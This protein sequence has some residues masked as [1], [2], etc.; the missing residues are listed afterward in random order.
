[1]PD[2]RVAVRTTADAL[3]QIGGGHPWLY[4]DSIT[5]VSDPSAPS[6]SLAVVFDAKRRFAAIGL[7]DPESPIRVR[8]LHAGEARPIDDSFWFELVAGA[9]E[10]RAGLPAE[11]TTAYRLLN[12]ENDGTGGL[13]ADLYRDTIVVKV[14]TSAWI[15]HLRTVLDALDIV[16]GP[17]RIV[18]R[19]GRAMARSASTSAAGLSDGLTIRGEPPT[20]PVQYTENGLEF[21]A[22][23][24]R[25]QK[26]G[27]FLDQR[28][29][30]RRL[31][32]R[33]SGCRV[34]DVFSG[35]GGFSVHAA[36]GGAAVV[37]AIDQSPH[38]ISAA[39][40]N[41]ALNAELTSPARFRTSTGDAFDIMATLA[42]RGERSD[43]VVV[44]PPAFATSKAD[45]DRAIRA[46]R[47]LTELALPLIERD[48]L[49]IQASC[50]ARVSESDLVEIVTSAARS[51]ARRLSDLEITG[52]GVDHPVTFPQGRYLKAVFAR[53]A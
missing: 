9:A 10:R 51:R 19:L 20:G 45:H 33:S 52:H 4:A 16:Y 26:T 41:M 17:E 35:S 50:S 34:L 39:R 23:V 40:E 11:G 24:I 28:E 48:G 1:M 18:V 14:Y 46:Y 6:G 30:R 29:N 31:R 5:S 22:D 44:D 53:V 12:G 38:A 47:R 36:A 42:G 37:H 32:E 3:R 49:L 8:I 15:P 13:V 7:W 27:T 2:R 21:E 25:G 43:V